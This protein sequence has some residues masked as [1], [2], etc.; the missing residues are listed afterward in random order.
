MSIH[1]SSNSFAPCAVC[2][3]ERPQHMRP[4]SLRYTER[5]RD[6]LGMP[7]SSTTEHSF[8][9]TIPI[10]GKCYTRLANQERFYCWRNWVGWGA[11]GMV[12]LVAGILKV[13]NLE[14]SQLGIGRLLDF[15]FGSLSLVAIGA[16][17]L[18]L[19]EAM[20]IRDRVSGNVARWLTKYADPNPFLSM[21][22]FIQ[23]ERLLSGAAG[24][25]ELIKDLPNHRP[26]TIKALGVSKAPQA[27]DALAQTF[28]FRPDPNVLDALLASGDQRTAGVL[29]EVLKKPYGQTAEFR[30][31]ALEALKTLGVSNEQIAESIVV[32]VRSGVADSHVVSE[33]VELGDPRT[34]ETLL[35][36]LKRPTNRN[37]AFK[38]E[39]IAKLASVGRGD[40]QVTNALVNV[41]HDQDCTVRA[42]AA[43]AL[44]ELGDQSI[45]A[46]LVESLQ[47]KS[48]G[49]RKN[50]TEALH[51][52][53]PTNDLISRLFRSQERAILIGGIVI[54][55]TVPLLCGLLWFALRLDSQLSSS[56]LPA[57]LGL[58][59]LTTIPIG[60]GVRNLLVN[61]KRRYQ[62]FREKWMQGV[63]AQPDTQA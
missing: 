14:P 48:P 4:F 22:Q 45:T 53:Y 59:S 51:K 60:V 7:S 39:A 25:E 41:L 16:L 54:A 26:Q 52:L 8:T 50:A 31:K 20:F 49:V 15:V 9:F 6:L 12:F 28:Q 30:T 58:L 57:I 32:S 43:T 33:L 11:I 1:Y 34:V 10:C 62:Q 44:G 42:A 5:H 18:W 36:A 2:H 19:I 46:I 13:F 24:V 56:D 35:D 29:L 21:P 55:S 3:K 61:S 38:V 27:F 23:E 37:P 63:Q 17:L 47:D 40:S